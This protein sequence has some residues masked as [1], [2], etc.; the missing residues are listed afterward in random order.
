MLTDTAPGEARTVQLAAAANE[1]E[2]FR[3][4]V[5][6][7]AEPLAA[8]TLTATDLRSG[9]AIV[10]AANLRFYR[11]HYVHVYE[12]SY[13]SSAPPGWYPDALV[14]FVDPQSG[15]PVTGAR[16]AGQPFDVEP[17]T[18]QGVWVDVYVPH[19]TAP[20]HYTGQVSVA[21]GGQELAVVPVDL[22]VWAFELPD[23]IAMRSRFGN[24]PQR[25][26]AQ[27][28]LEV[29][30]PEFAA[31]EELYIDELLAHRAIPS[32]LGRIWPTWS[33]E[34]G[35]DVSQTDDRLR[36][37]IEKRHINA[38]S[39]PFPRYADPQDTREHMGALAEYLRE[40]GWLDL[41]YVYMKDEPNNAEEYEIVRQQGALIQEADPG[42]LRMCTEQTVTSNLEWGDL[43]G[44][45]D[46]WCP[47]WG[48]WDE[49][50][51]RERLALGERLWSYT[52]LCQRDERNPFWQIDFPPVVYRAP[53][54]TSWHY[55]IEGFL[56]WSAVYWDYEDIWTR[57]F[58][59]D[60][61]WGEGMLLYPGTDAGISGPAPSIRLKL[62]REAAE[63][64]EYMTLAAAR[65][66]KAQVDEIVAEITTSFLEWDR[67]PA[68]YYA[69]RARLAELLQQ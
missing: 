46:I 4:I 40:R 33:K 8:V 18:N 45:V 5:R 37:M 20:G 27:L 54:W 36:M 65:G 2:P 23:T 19:G 64:F 32:S 56:Y 41:A 39:F 61:F 13:R 55:D 62:I 42:I 63:D 22:T 30:S 35:L 57:P 50:T 9:E 26:A 44:A 67:D 25:V 24:S 52:A 51:A 38:L 3:I 43:Y 68:A 17:E 69:A 48:L 12:P 7:G 47:L 11:E 6:A 59:R 10:P 15:A 21:A 53:Y 28:G 49:E 31:V 16:F 66:H 58:F 1:Y 14:P 34:E 60:R 29:N